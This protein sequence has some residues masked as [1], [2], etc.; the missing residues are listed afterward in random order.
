V[1]RTPLPI[2]PYPGLDWPA[3][4]ACLFNNCLAAWPSSSERVMPHF[5][6]GSSAAAAGRS[7]VHGGGALPVASTAAAALLFLGGYLVYQANLLCATYAGPWRLSHW[8]H[9]APKRQ[10]AGDSSHKCSWF[11]NLPACWPVI[12]LVEL[13]K[14]N[15]TKWTLLN[16]VTGKSEVKQKLDRIVLWFQSQETLPCQLES[17]LAIIRFWWSEV[18]ARQKIDLVNQAQRKL[19]W[20]IKHRENLHIQVSNWTAVLVKKRFLPGPI[21]TIL[22]RSLH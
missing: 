15:A 10:T 18:R 3:C 1:P 22:G 19:T 16:Q 20:W 14:K 7:G 8:L 9:P 4:S 17:L 11:R 13:T 2:F 6:W 5:G 12:E 21:K